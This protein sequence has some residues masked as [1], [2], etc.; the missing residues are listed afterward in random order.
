LD[1]L[2]NVTAKLGGVD[3]Q[4]WLIDMLNRIAGHK[5]TKLDELMPWLYADETM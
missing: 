2:E 4:T 1:K 5:N 3:Q